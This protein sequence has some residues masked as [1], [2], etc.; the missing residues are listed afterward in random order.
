[1]SSPTSLSVILVALFLCCGCE[2]PSGPL[3]HTHSLCAKCGRSRDVASWH[4][5]VKSSKVQETEL[6]RWLAT[7]RSGKCKHEWIQVSGNTEAGFYWDGTSLW[8]STLLRIK[9]LEPTIGRAKTKELLEEYYAI[10]NMKPGRDQT[11][12]IAMFSRDLDERLKQ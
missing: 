8:D 2:T 3:A 9:D 11:R 7:Y 10:A 12:E 6:S 5:S 4:G 1:M